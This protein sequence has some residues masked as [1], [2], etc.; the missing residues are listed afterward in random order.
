MSSDSDDESYIAS[1]ERKAKQNYL[2]E[3]IVENNYDPQLFTY[4]CELT[5]PPDLDF[6]T[7]DELVD[8][9]AAFKMKF[10]RGQSFEEVMEKKG[11]APQREKKVEENKDSTKEHET[12]LEKSQE[13]PVK[14]FLGFTQSQVTTTLKTPAGEDPLSLSKEAKK[15]KSSKIPKKDQENLSSDPFSLYTIRC[16]VFEDSLLSKAKNLDFTL[17]DPELKDGGFLS[18]NYYIY[19]VSVFSLNWSC[20]RKYSDFLWLHETLTALFPG[21]FLRPLHQVSALS[22]GKGESELLSKRV[23]SLKEFL[24]WLTCSPALL[25]HPYTENFFRIPSQVDFSKYIKSQK[26]KTGKPENLELC[27]SNNG[28]LT[29]NLS[30]LS[31]KFEVLNK[32]V[33]LGETSNKILKEKAA[34]VIKNMKNIQDDFK[35]IQKGLSDLESFHVEMIQDS[36]GLFSHVSSGFKELADLEGKKVES[37]RQH[38]RQFFAY[39]EL[40]KSS[41]KEMIKVKENAYQEYKRAEARPKTNDQA[42]DWFGFLNQQICTETIRVINEETLVNLKNFSSFAKK[43]S[44]IVSNSQNIY[45][46]LSSSLKFK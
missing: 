36:S 13:K 22:L 32:F 15:E 35:A 6:W 9:V 2:F 5:K 28:H 39:R 3:E 31:E 12:N 37:F 25:S 30:D 26:K 42:K 7:F 1:A 43:A 4:F 44:E 46:S 8:C 45:S 23:Y 27:F 17:H 40:E 33:S 29:C 10:R 24:S 18:S 38:F 34:V 16:R 11:N 20:E 14:K 21:H 41:L 19:R